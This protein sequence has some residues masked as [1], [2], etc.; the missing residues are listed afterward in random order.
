MKPHEII[1]QIQQEQVSWV[2][3]NFGDRPAWMPLLGIVEEVG[4]LEEAQSFFLPTITTE[5]EIKKGHAELS[6]YHYQG[7]PERA[8]GPADAE[9]ADK[10]KVWRDTQ[11]SMLERNAI[12]DTVIFTLDFCTAMQWDAGELWR[13]CL[14]TTAPMNVLVGRLS[15]HYLKNAQGIRITED[16]NEAMNQYVRAIFGWVQNRMGPVESVVLVQSTWDRVKQR[17]WKLNPKKGT[18]DASDND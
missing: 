10:L 17:D 18:V 3:H 4:E 9:H 15:H 2:R 7:V 11:G 8:I 1:R 14:M 12:A 5:E 6:V 13:N 16:H